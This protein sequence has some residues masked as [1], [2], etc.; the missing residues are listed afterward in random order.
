MG[1]LAEGEAFFDRDEVIGRA[2][3][4]L[5]TSNLLLLA[6]RRVGKSS[7]LNRM[8]E[9]GPARDYKTLYLSIPDAEDELDFIKR[10]T[11][12]FRDTDW[13]TDSRNREVHE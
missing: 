9:D 11:R 4:L 12:A 13:A 10:L 3:D 5:K 1:R 8:K 2:W 6:P 7:L